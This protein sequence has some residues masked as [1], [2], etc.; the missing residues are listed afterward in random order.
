MQENKVPVQVIR[1]SVIAV[2]IIAII[3]FKTIT[4]NIVEAKVDKLLEAT[5]KGVITYESASM[6]IIGLEVCI[7]D[8]TIKAANGKSIKI[9]EIVINDIDTDNDIP[10]YMDIEINDIEGD[11]ETLK[12]DR[13]SAKLIDMLELKELVSDIAFKYSF[14]K[15]ENILEIDDVSFKVEDLGKLAFEV[16]LHGVQSLSG[17]GMQMMMAPQNLKIASASIEYDNYADKELISAMVAVSNGLSYDESKAKSLQKLSRTIEELKDEDDDI[18]SELAEMIHDFYED[19]K[20]F[21]I[22]ISP[23]NAVSIREIT[24]TQ[25]AKEAK[26]LLNFKVEVN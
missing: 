9:D 18:A 26:E 1:L 5:P 7:N 3:V 23:E 10:Q 19:P 4:S 2:V 16:E 25:S 8:V 13:N 15:E 6:D 20:S 11:L 17:L 22:S 14:D 21:E 12:L 24:G